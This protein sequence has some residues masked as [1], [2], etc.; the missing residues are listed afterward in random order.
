[1]L[2]SVS[3]ENVIIVKLFSVKTRCR[4]LQY[5][6]NEPNKFEMKFWFA[7]DVESKYLINGFPH[8]GKDE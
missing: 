8:L 3:G 5:V 4:F 1:M 6:A 7:V 2:R